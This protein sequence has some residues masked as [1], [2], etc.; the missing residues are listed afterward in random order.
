MKLSS[1]L[2]KLTYRALKVD[3]KKGGKE[4]HVGVKWV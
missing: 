2:F 4:Y 1:W 3:L